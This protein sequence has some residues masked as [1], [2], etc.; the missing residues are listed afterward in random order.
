[1]SLPRPASPRAL[2]ADLRAFAGQRSRLQ[3]VAAILAILMPTIIVI[4][5]I[6]DA[7]TNIM[8]GEQLI[9]VDSWSANRSD[10]EIIAAQKERQKEKEAADKQRQER[11][12]ELER[13]LGL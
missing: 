13:R 9:Y 10:A 12:Q 2:W 8:P 1:M 7:R 5:F 3:W 11:Y 4:G 6:L